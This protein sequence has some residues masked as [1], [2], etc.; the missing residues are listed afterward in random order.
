MAQSKTEQLNV[1]L[2]KTLLKGVEEVA[3]VEQLDRTAVIRRL[4]AEGLERYRLDRAARLY[5]EGRISKA[6]AAEMAGISVYEMLDEIEKRGLRSPY[7]LEDMRQDLEM[8]CM[9]YAR[10][11]P[12]RRKPVLRNTTS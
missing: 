2:P 11:R 12:I 10:S 4:I 6:R 9:R 8:L 7:T 1:R 3:E 5:G